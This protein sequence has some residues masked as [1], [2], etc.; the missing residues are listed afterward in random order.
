MGVTV[1]MRI[2]QVRNLRDTPVEFHYVGV[3]NDSNVRSRTSF[4]HAKQRR[5]HWYAYGMDIQG[6]GEQLPTCRFLA[7]RV[8]GSHVSHGKKQT[9][10]RLTGSR[11]VP[12]KGLH[13]Q[14]EIS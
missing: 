10:C 6:L 12:E 8:D 5:Q 14:L 7:C 11:I 9:I 1:K 3:L 4:I 2:G 13:I